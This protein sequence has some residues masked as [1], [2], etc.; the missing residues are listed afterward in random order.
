M[1]SSTGSPYFLGYPTEN[2]SVQVHTDIQSLAED[3]VNALDLKLS[4]TGG[5]LTG[6]LTVPSLNIGSGG[7][8]ILSGTGS[9]ESV[10]TAPIG[11]I[12]FQTDSTVG[13]THWRKATGAG[14]TGWVVMSGDTG[15]R[16]LGDVDFVIAL[17]GQSLTVTCVYLQRRVNDQVYTSVDFKLSAAVTGTGSG[18]TVSYDIPE[19]L[20]E[21]FGNVTLQGPPAT[22]TGNAPILVSTSHAV[23]TGVP[24]PNNYY[25]RLLCTINSASAGSLVADQWYTT[26]SRIPLVVDSPWPT[27]LPGT[28]A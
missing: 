7:P 20:G 8:Q 3:A 17:T 28:A 15:W 11:S 27:S 23:D 18:T 6:S 14:D 13:I 22:A 25:P 21:G 5:T 12:W 2:D 9:P 4:L 1:P 19:L 10:V 26:L 16:I 24:D